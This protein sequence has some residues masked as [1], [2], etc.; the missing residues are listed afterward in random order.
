MDHLDFWY[1]CCLAV[2]EEDDKDNYSKSAFLDPQA[3]PKYPNLVPKIEISVFLQQR[4]HFFMDHHYF[5]F[6]SCFGLSEKKDRRIFQICL[7]RPQQWAQKCP[8]LVPKMKISVFQQFR[9]HFFMDLHRFWFVSCFRVDKE[10]DKKR[11]F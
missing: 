11:I 5:L 3:P 1:V 4:V 7:F 6:V 10:E 9:V 8:N 2:S